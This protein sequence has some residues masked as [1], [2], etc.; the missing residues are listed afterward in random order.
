MV[1]Q[2]WMWGVIVSG[3]FHWLIDAHTMKS[4]FP[5]FFLPFLTFQDFL[6]LGF[7]MCLGFSDNVLFLECSTFRMYFL[8]LGFISHFLGF[9]YFSIM[10]SR[11]PENHRILHWLID[12][13]TMNP[14][15]HSCQTLPLESSPYF[16][17]FMLLYLFIYLSIYLFY[18]MYYILL[19]FILFFYLLYFILFHFILCYLILFYVI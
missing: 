12:A 9:P 16:I 4:R 15:V 17:L 3:F 14:H 10:K 7:L 18:F 13:Q 5:L 8:L 6:L 11:N 1:W 19:Y 2:L